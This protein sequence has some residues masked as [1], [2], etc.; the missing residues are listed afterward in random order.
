MSSNGLSPHPPVQ[1]IEVGPRDGLQNEPVSLTVNRKVAFVNALSWTGVSEIEVGAFVSER[2]NSQMKDS[3][4]VLRQIIRRDHV[5]YSALVPNERGLDRAMAVD[6]QKVSVFTAASDQFTLHNIHATIEES[7]ARFRPVIRRAQESG[8][9]TRGYISSVVYCPYAGRIQPLK[10]HDVA[11]QLIDIGVEEISLGETMGKAVPSDIRAL[12][13]VVCEAVPIN[14]IALHLHDTY[15]MAVTN[16]LMAWEQYGISLFDASAGGLGG[17]PYAPGA[18]GNVATEDLA[19]ALKACG[20]PVEVDE[21][22]VVMAV[23]PIFQ[24]LGKTMTSKLS[25]VPA[26]EKHGAHLAQ[27]S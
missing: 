18:S 2:A 4:E 1:V 19:W 8:L 12:L 10:V 25:R 14:M 17:C 20:A 21:K 15:G 11:K 22:N 13:D 5:R 7:I 16:A 23:E 27:C 9:S 26:P 3:D 24:A 6:V